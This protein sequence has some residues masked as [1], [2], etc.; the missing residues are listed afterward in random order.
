MKILGGGKKPKRYFTESGITAYT[1]LRE[2]EKNT[3]G[4]PESAINALSKA[5]KEKIAAVAVNSQK[6]A[7]DPVIAMRMIQIEH[8][9]RISTAEY[10][11]GNLQEEMRSMQL[12]REEAQQALLALPEPTVST[13]IRTVRSLIVELVN[14]YARSREIG[15]G[16]IW[17]RIYKE[18]SIQ[19]QTN[20]RLHATK[21]KIK[22]L[23]WIE[24]S[25]DIN[26]LYAIAKEILT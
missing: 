15:H 17:N 25:G 9:E 23:D 21:E 16:D 26:L 12:R 10:R 6:Y 22:Q 20:V 18:Y 1:T 11:I 14:A 24:K 7:Q 13:R 19:S 3:Q 4:K 5:G 2:S 8:E